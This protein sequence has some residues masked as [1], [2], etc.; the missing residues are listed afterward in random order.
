MQK[1]QHKMQKG[2]ENVQ[3]CQEEL[4]D[5][6]EE[7]I[8]SV[9]GRIAGKMKEKIARMEDLEKKLLA[10]GNENKNQS[11]P[12]SA[13]PK[14]M[15]ASPVPVTA[16]TGLY[17]SDVERLA[18]LAFS[19]HPATVRDAICLQ[20]FVDGLKDGEIQKAVRIA[21]VQDLKS[22]LL[23]FL[24][25]EATAQASRRDRQSIRGARVTADEPC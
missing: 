20:Y 14:P 21:D 1:G 5:S 3:T 12:V 11:V 22:A 6:L 19:D 25:L 2:L 17:A 23:Y 13:F 16:F 24:K 18:D 4:K 10:G 9:E 8:N 7:K 15:L